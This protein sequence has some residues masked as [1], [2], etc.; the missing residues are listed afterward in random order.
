V[1]TGSLV[2][3]G[4]SL[5]IYVIDINSLISV[6]LKFIIESFIYRTTIKRNY[7]I[8]VSSINYYYN[9]YF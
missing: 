3:I 2:Y 7:L 1:E 9:Q 8:R 4:H 5:I 6:E